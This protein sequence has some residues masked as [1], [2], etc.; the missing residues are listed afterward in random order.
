MRFFPL[1]LAIFIS[2]SNNCMS[3]TTPETLLLKTYRPKSIYKVPI[4][5]IKKAKFPVIDM[6]FHAYPKD[7]KQIDQWVNIM[8]EVE[9]EKTIILS[10]EIGAKFDS[11]YHAYTG[12]Y[13]DRFEVW[14]GFDY[15]GYDQPGF[16]PAALAELERCYKIGV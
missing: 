9:I 15:S 4:T 6:H 7:A 13:P 3:Q 8:D 16:G 2:V 12:Q 11:V 5:E 1:L 14:C 10:K